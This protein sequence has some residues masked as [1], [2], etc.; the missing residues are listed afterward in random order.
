MLQ[1]FSNRRLTCF[2]RTTTLDV[3]STSTIQNLKAQIQDKEGNPSDQQRL[4]FGGKQLTD[5][6]TLSDYNISKESTI[7]L[8]LIYLNFKNLNINLINN[9]SEQLKI[10]DNQFYNNIVIIGILIILTAIT[11]SAMSIMSI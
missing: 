5:S 9:I 2:G 6:R 8:V 1:N 11:K 3:E 7:H 10:I 4:I